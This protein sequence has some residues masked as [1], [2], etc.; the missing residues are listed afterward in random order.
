MQLRPSG[1]KGPVA[2]RFSAFERYYREEAWVWELLALTRLRVVAGDAA[3]AAR[4][5]R[6]AAAALSAP[7]DPAGLRAE[8]ASMRTRMERERPADGPW[9]LKLAPGG[10]VDLEFIAQ[11]L[12]LIAA[13]TDPA[14]IQPA[15]DDAFAALHRA[16]AL[17]EADTALLRD[18]LALATNLQQVLRV[19]FDGRFDPV[20]APD[21]LKALLARTAGAGDFPALE[22]RLIETQRAVRAAFERL[23]G[24]V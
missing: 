12:T 13:Q 21:A 18:A 14:V 8:A 5:E 4:V 10:L 24:P 7:R 20:A 3:L 23:V 1:R 6:S 15:T 16:G 17:S 22:A 9:D 19:G 2:V 11:T